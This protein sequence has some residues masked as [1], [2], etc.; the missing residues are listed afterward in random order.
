VTNTIGIQPT[1]TTSS[2]T[3]FALLITVFETRTTH[4]HKIQSQLV[5]LTNESS[6]PQHLRTTMLSIMSRTTRDSR[7]FPTV[8]T[9][10]LTKQMD[11]LWRSYSKASYPKPHTTWLTRTS[12]YGPLQKPLQW[13]C[14][15][16]GTAIATPTSPNHSTAISN[17][18]VTITPWTNHYSLA[19]PHTPACTTDQQLSVLCQNYTARMANSNSVMENT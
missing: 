8:H 19:W 14:N 12:T 9:H 13:L 3:P 4:N 18:V 5:T 11:W 10:G 1:L 15:T 6:C 16:S 2:G 7:P 17:R